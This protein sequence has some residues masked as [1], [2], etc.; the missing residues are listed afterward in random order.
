MN[1]S[2]MKMNLIFFQEDEA[3]NVALNGL[4]SR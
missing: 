3:M 1:L 4:L 2:F